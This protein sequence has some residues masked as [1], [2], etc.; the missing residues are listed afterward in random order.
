MYNI[1]ITIEIIIFIF[2]HIFILSF[3]TNK[4]MNKYTIILSTTVCVLM[5]ALIK[6]EKVIIT[7][8]GTVKNKYK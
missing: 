3:Y 8:S 5:N 4:Y 1:Y 2:S 7:Y 6:K